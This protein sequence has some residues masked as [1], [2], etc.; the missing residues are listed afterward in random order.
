MRWSWRADSLLTLLAL[1]AEGAWLAV[2]YAAVQVVV[3]GQVP[4]LGTFELTIAAAIAAVL[5]R[6]RLLDPDERPLTFFAATVAAGVAGW[7]VSPE[8]RALLAAGNLA[9]A[10]GL[11]PGGWLAAAAFLRGVGRAFE[12]DDRAVTRLVLWGTPGLALPWIAGQLAPEPLRGVFVEQ[13]FVA[14][15]TFVSAGFMAAG[16]ARLQVIGQETGVDWRENRSWLG[17]LVGVL[18][19]VLAVGVPA[20][21][22]LGLPIE[23]V[24]RGILGP[25]GTLLGYLILV[26]LIPLA[27]LAGL[28][29][30]LLLGLGLRLPAPGGPPKPG[31]LFGLPETYDF[32]QVRGGLLTVGIFWV[33]VLLLAV[34]VGR[35]WLRRRA[36][37]AARGA[38]EERFIR[39]P[40]TRLRLALPRFSLPRLHPAP[41]P[42][43]A[44]SAYL[45]A[46]ELYSP[47]QLMRRDAESPRAHAQRV[48]DRQ[49][50]LLAADYALARY[51]G[52]ALTRLED[53]RALGRWRRLR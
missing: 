46:L 9:E 28:L 32:E 39:L 40:E 24:A 22:L 23:A 5:A 20:A 30:E 6:R 26:I 21:Y 3:G 11:H 52:R 18:A 50:S 53:L 38:S 36:R 45:A 1:V 34:I 10:I 35:T 19:V 51:A 25:L 37:R 43:D 12:V 2:V 47:G 49:L 15:L 29:T 4:L 27:W 8:A 13:A 33:L 14:S 42:H 17:L 31:E 44:V 16:L 48:A 7:L 41:D